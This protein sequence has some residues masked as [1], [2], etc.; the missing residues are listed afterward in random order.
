MKRRNATVNNG[1]RQTRF[2]ATFGFAYQSG[3]T[4]SVNCEGCQAQ[5]GGDGQSSRSLEGKRS[6]QRHQARRC[7]RWRPKGR[8]AIGGSMR[9][10]TA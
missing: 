8:E 1:R 5:R 6:A 7:Q 10:T 4:C 2:D 3:V 9:T